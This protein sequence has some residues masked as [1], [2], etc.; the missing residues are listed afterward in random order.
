MCVALEAYSQAALSSSIR[1]GPWIQP[2]VFGFVDTSAGD[3]FGFES[4]GDC[5]YRHASR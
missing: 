4:V 3:D 5:R 2:T 1:V